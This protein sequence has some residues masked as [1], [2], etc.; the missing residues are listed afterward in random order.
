MDVLLFGGSPERLSTERKDALERAA[1]PLRVVITDDHDEQLSVLDDVVVAAREVAV[2]HLVAAPRLRWYHRWYAGVEDLA[3][4]EDLR[5]K[6]VVITNARGVHAEPMAEQVFAMLLAFARRLHTSIRNQQFAQWKRLSSHELDELAGK[7]LLVVGFGA[8]GKRVAEIGRAFRMEVIG[9][10]RTSTLPGLRCVTIDQLAEVLPEADVVV[11]VLP[12]TPLTRKVFNASM[13]AAMKPGSWFVN[14]G[15]GGLVDHDA[16]VQA[17][18]SGQIGAA[19]LDVTDPEPLP[20]S[21]PLWSMDNVI[22]SPHVGGF[23]PHYND[24]AWP[25]FLDNLQRFHRNEELKNVVNLEAGY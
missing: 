17:L 15:R 2:E 10:S 18:R 5:R 12:L 11:C 21:S 4:I 1:K 14:V 7:T 16:L 20:E 24:R 6:G 25:I 8:I 9:V 23:T 19:G 3:E 13:F 22:I